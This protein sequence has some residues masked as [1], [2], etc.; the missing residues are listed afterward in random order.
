[1]KEEPGVRYYKTPK[2][3][4]A[5]D[6]VGEGG[7]KLSRSPKSYADKMGAKRGFLSDCRNKTRIGKPGAMRER[8]GA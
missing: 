3:R 7:T 6:Y 8:E 1:M 5:W 4:W 2:G